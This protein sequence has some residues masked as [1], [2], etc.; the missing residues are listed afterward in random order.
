MKSDSYS[1]LKIAR[2]AGVACLLSIVIVVYA[3]FG[4]MDKLVTDDPA[5]TA[6]NIL[7]HEKLY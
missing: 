7:S 2:V 6:G 1:L 5:A 3:N 4:I